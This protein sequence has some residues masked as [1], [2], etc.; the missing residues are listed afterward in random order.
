MVIYRNVKN[1]C[2]VVGISI[3]NGLAVDSD[4][5][6]LFQELLAHHKVIFV[7]WRDNCMLQLMLS[8]G[9]LINI[10]VNIFTGDILKIVFDKY[11]MGKLLSEYVTDGKH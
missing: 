9:I 3:E 1:Y 8:S 5:S 10:S 4:K 7:K 2:A 6:D 11:L